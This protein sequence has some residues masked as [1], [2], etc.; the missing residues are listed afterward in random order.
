MRATTAC[1]AQISSALPGL[2]GPHAGALQ[3]PRRARGDAGAVASAL[4]R[5]LPA[6]AEP[7][8]LLEV[9]G[10][11]RGRPLHLRTFLV[12]GQRPPFRTAPRDLPRPRN[13]APPPGGPRAPLQ[14]PGRGGRARRAPPLSWSGTSPGTSPAECWPTASP[15]WPALRAGAR[16]WCPFSCNSR[17]VCPSC[18]ARRAHETAVQ[19][20]ERVRSVAAGFL[21]VM[22]LP[23]ALAL[24]DVQRPATAAAPASITESAPESMHVAQAGS[25]VGPASDEALLAM[26]PASR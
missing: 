7:L 18:N 14:L 4:R 26:S 17:G 3:G 25:D 13:H 1:R 6:L 10:A 16:W 19:L 15:G 24:A 20:V 9:A 22:G 23:V 8:S 11:A 5:V 21:C 12:L 2:P